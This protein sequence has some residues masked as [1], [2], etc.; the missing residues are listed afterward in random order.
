MMVILLRS[1]WSMNVISWQFFALCVLDMT[2]ILWTTPL[3]DIFPWNAHIHIYNV[4]SAVL[5]STPKYDQ[6]VF[7]SLKSNSL[8]QSI[9]IIIMVKS[10]SH[11][12]SS[13]G[14]V[15][16]RLRENTRPQVSIVLA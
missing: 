16:W 12:T 14:Y 5:H 7:I 2:F 3:L 1:F 6:L 11:H 4:A 8:S 15:M 9:L 13:L 10:I